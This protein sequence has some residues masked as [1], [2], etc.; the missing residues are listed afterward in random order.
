MTVDL[1]VA[2]SDKYTAE[3]LVEKLGLTVDDVLDA[4]EDAVKLEFMDGGKLE[5][6]WREFYGEI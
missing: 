1:V 5:D 4:F 2:L 3:E 6:E